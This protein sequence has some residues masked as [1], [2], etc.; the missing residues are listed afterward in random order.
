MHRLE[1][2]RIMQRLHVFEAHRIPIICNLAAANL[3]GFHALSLPITTHNAGLAN[4][5]MARR[6]D[7][8]A[9]HIDIATL[10]SLVAIQPV[11]V[12]DCLN[13]SC[14]V[15][16]RVVVAATLVAFDS[17]EELAIHVADLG[18]AHFLGVCSRTALLP[19]QHLGG[20]A[21]KLR[22]LGDAF[23]RQLAHVVCVALRRRMHTL[24]LNGRQAKVSCAVLLQTLERLCLLEL[25]DE[26]HVVLKRVNFARVALRDA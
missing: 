26:L 5:H 17:G 6:L 2:G 16:R 8:L 24:L 11:V 18:L 9:R 12:L 14:H 20:H 19:N 13:H 10:H 22:A 4:L 1:L 25:L 7:E 15:R 3:A 23:A 21:G